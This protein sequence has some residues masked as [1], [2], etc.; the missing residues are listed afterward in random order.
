MEFDQ[1]PAQINVP[2]TMLKTIPDVVE[3]VLKELR[4]A[5]NNLLIIQPSCLG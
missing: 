3:L 4:L 1:M 5:R 2:T